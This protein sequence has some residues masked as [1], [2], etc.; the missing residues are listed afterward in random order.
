MILL[1]EQM[2][3]KP[4]VLIVEDDTLILKAMKLKYAAKG[5]LI[6]T[7]SDGVEALKILKKW[8]P[9]V[10]ILD[11]L[12]P[13]KDGYEV[14][15]EIKS[16]EKLKGMPVLIASNLS[17][18]KDI[19]KG[20]NLSAAEFFVKSDLSLDDLLAKTIYHIQMSSH[21]RKSMGL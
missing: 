8:V 21:G 15:K 2:I 14:L 1:N 10:V 3:N 6:K 12:M 11:I 18:E 4:K 19:S 7:A 9:S 16:D 17:Q 20:M 13:N 5:F